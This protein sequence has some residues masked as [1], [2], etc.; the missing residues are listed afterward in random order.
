VIELELA[1]EETDGTSSTCRGVPCFVID[2]E[3]L[4]GLVLSHLTM[5]LNYGSRNLG[6]RDACYVAARSRRWAVL[7]HEWR[8]GVLAEEEIYQEVW[9]ERRNE[10]HRVLVAVLEE[11]GVSQLQG[12]S[13]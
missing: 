2:D 3:R 12:Q 1:R 7:G 13:R 5:L 6:K 4:K 11:S 10:K 9:R 8:A